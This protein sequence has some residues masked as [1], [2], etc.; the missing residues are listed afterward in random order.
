MVNKEIKEET[1]TDEKELLHEKWLNGVNESYV[2]YDICRNCVSFV[3]CVLFFQFPKM[4][5]KV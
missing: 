4:Y 3:D 5:V 1:K 2:G